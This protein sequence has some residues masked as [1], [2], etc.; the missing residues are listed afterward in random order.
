MA[1]VISLPV[2]R[3][4]RAFLN[5]IA[6]DSPTPWQA[7]ISTF[8]GSWLINAMVKKTVRVKEI[9]RQQALKNGYSESWRFSVP[10]RHNVIFMPAARV[11]EFNTMLT[12]FL[13]FELF[14]ELEEAAYSNNPLNI[15]AVIQ[16]FRDERGISDNDMPDD[17]LRKQYQRFRDRGRSLIQEAGRIVGPSLV[18]DNYYFR[19][20]NTHNPPFE[21]ND[22]I[23]NFCELPTGMFTL[24]FLPRHEID[25]WNGNTPIPRYRWYGVRPADNSFRFSPSS[26]STLH[27]AP[28]SVNVSF[29]IISDDQATA[30]QLA[31]MQDMR[32]VLRLR[33]Y[34]GKTRIIGQPTEYCEMTATHLELPEK[35]GLGGWR[36]TFEGVFTRR[37]V[38]IS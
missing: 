33:N 16:S 35:Q 34:K 15:H 12:R 28:I 10:S 2:T 27:G 37:P 21:M 18:S 6:P 13:L 23:S 3:P 19:L 11:R 31:I 25:G 20:K 24:D 1:V 26:E 14:Q 38:I 36:I 29:L 30:D 4:V 9:T 22:L 7:S 17:T 5:R 8:L 32:F